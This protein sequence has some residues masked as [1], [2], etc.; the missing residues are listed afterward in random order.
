M[1]NFLAISDILV[2][3]NLQQEGNRVEGHLRDDKNSNLSLAG[4]VSGTASDLFIY[5]H[6]VKC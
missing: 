4:V 1:F 5:F 2:R 6:V 3:D